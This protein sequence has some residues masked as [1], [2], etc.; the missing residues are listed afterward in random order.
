MAVIVEDEPV[1]QKRIADLTG[2]SQASVSLILQ[3]L[4]LL[5]PIRKMR[6]QGDRKN[7]YAYEAPHEEF[8]LDLWKQRVEAQDLD[9]RLIDEFLRTTDCTRDYLNRFC[10]Y[11]QNMRLFLG[12]TLQIRTHILDAYRK[13]LSSGSIEDLQNEY[14]MAETDSREIPE[15]LQAIIENAVRFRAEGIKGNAPEN[16]EYLLLK[17]KYFSRIKESIN[18]LY[19]QA[20]ANQLVVVHHVLLEGSSTQDEIEQATHL[21]RSTISEVLTQSIN[22]KILVFERTARIKHYQPRITLVELLLQSYDLFDR[23]ADEAQEKLAEL[24][25]RT[26][27]VKST[28]SSAKHFLKLLLNLKKSYSFTQQ[29]SRSMKVELIL[30]LKRELDS[31][32]IFV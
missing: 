2:F 5:F 12:Q 18:P 6:K 30:R 19:S 21:P 32:F 31:G 27:K 25:S 20:I 10:I 3:R 28:S 22:R 15:N 23:Q 8:I 1:T 13:T 14:T 16:D 4:E 17:S 26:R 24:I 29:V 9:I 7:Y 11:L